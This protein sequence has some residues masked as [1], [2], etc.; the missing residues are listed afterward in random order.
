MRALVGQPHSSGWF[1]TRTICATKLD[2]VDY[3]FNGDRR[4]AEGTKVVG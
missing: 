4:L 3:V 2:S 1:Y